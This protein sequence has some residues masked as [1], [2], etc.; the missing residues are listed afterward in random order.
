MNMKYEPMLSFLG[1][2]TLRAHAEYL[3][4]ERLRHSIDEKSIAQIKG[5]TPR[6]ISSMNIKR[7]IREEVVKRL[8]NIKLHDCY[9]ASYTLTP[10]PCPLI[11]KHYSS[12]NGFLYEAEEL[13][14][15][16]DWG[17]LYVALD[18]RKVPRSYL[19]GSNPRTFIKDTPILALDLCEHA[20]F[21]DY[22]FDRKRYVRAALAH[23]DLSK[24][25]LDTKK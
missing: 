7:S 18:E 17:F 8:V 21:S 20:Y 13:A 11:K 9:F 14:L 6:E 5:R 25:I 10:A 1:E 19:S 3:R 2:D 23:L 15:S 22:S 12:E 16:A 4:G 24:L